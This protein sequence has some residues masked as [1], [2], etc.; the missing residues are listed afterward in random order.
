MS[1]YDIFWI[2]WG[3]E[4]GNDYFLSQ[5]TAKN[6]HFWPFSPTS[7]EKNTTLG[8]CILYK[9]YIFLKLKATRN[10]NMKFFKCVVKAVTY[11]FFHKKMAHYGHKDIRGCLEGY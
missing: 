1:Q 4:N 6:G 11:I 9:T 7:G 10:H 3:T 8:S 5:K 2:W